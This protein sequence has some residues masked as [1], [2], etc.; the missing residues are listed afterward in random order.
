MSADN[1]HE[2]TMPRAL[3][4][5]G[6]TAKMT[7]AAAHVTA[8]GRSKPSKNVADGDKRKQ[9][10]ANLAKAEAL[11]E[12]VEKSLTSTLHGELFEGTKSSN[13]TRH[14]Q[15][16]EM[17]ALRAEI[18]D[19]KTAIEKK[20]RHG[21]DDQ[22]QTEAKVSNKLN[23]NMLAAVKNIVT[24]EIDAQLR[25]I[26][27]REERRDERAQLAAKEAKALDNKVYTL[28]NKFRKINDKTSTST[29][30]A[31]VSKRLTALEAQVEALQDDND[32]AERVAALDFQVHKLEI[33]VKALQ[34]K[35]E[36]LKAEIERFREEG[37]AVEE[38]DFGDQGF[39]DGDDEYDQN[40]NYLD[41]ATRAWEPEEE[42][43]AVDFPETEYQDYEGEEASED[44][45]ID[46][47]DMY[48]EWDDEDEPLFGAY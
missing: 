29:P 42:G 27:I 16:P 26:K 24:Q 20:D 31:A 9:E 34:E 41:R 37:F 48:Y 43:Q 23:A 14:K 30:D 33:Q 5:K 3:P 17:F 15:M 32:H 18:Q 12:K 7:N 44:D 19:L 1:R 36:Q 6:V 35:N 22:E 38:T 47:D 46:P 11:A 10:S 8:T 13:A 4:Q 39:D 40:E 2:T 25:D 28:E 45:F 21:N